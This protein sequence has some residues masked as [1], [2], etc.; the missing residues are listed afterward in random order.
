MSALSRYI[1][2]Q[3]ELLQKLAKIK[4]RAHLNADA[5]YA[6]IRRDFGVVPDQRAGNSQISMVDALMSGFAMFSLKAPSLLA[7]DKQRYEEPEYLHSVFGV[8]AIPC[9]SQ[10]QTKWHPSVFVALF[11]LFS[12]SCNGARCCRK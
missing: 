8:E 7:F 5:M 10:M 6:A 11:D 12:T 4:M 3:Q 1:R 2:R 9:D